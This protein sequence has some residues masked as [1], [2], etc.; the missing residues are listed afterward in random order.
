MFENHQNNSIASFGQESAITA[1]KAPA[2]PQMLHRFGSNET[3]SVLSR[4]ITATSINSSS[5]INTT[6]ET[7][8]MPNSF[9]VSRKKYKISLKLKSTE[10]DLL[11]KSWAIVTSN[12]S[13][14]NESDGLNILSSRDSSMIDLNLMK[15]NTNSSAQ[16]GPA[17]SIV[18]PV[19]PANISTKQQSFNSASFASFL[20]CIQFYNNLIG[21]DPEIETLIPS[22]RH[23]ASAFAGVISVAISTLE[24]LSKMKESLLNL[25]HLHARILG[26]DSPYFKIMGEALIKTFQDWFGN[27]PESFPLELEEAWIKLY[28]FLANSIIQGGI[29]P[30]IEYNLQPS[31]KQT[32]GIDDTEQINEDDE[33][34]EERTDHLTNLQETD[35][36][37]NYNPTSASSTDDSTKKSTSSSRSSLANPNLYSNK[38]EPSINSSVNQQKS[39]YIPS[40]GKNINRLKKG[41]SGTNSGSKEDC[42]IM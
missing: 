27:S 28:C 5:T 21:M 12:E 35:I 42:T 6:F 11:R 8:W 24:D 18:P 7:N 1:G 9:V 32:V 29:D 2:S 17:S 36:S 38:Y 31:R 22:I 25:G 37:S 15:T 23:Q 30:I 34:D 39:S 19:N 14:A 4:S 20:F 13:R 26:I 41:R 40:V 10:I 3:L 33:I 16:T